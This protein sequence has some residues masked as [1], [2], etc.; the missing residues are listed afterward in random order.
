MIGIALLA[1][2]EVA[3][4]AATFVG[5]EEG[6]DGQSDLGLGS[7]KEHVIELGVVHLVLH[8]RSGSSLKVLPLPLREEYTDRGLEVNR[9][10]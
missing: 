4:Q 6:L 10:A 9:V 1:E 8:G 3:E 7:G 5:V 2:V